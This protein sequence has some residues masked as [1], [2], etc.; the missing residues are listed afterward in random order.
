M[1]AKIIVKTA[2]IYLFT[3][4]MV[5]FL[6][7]H[8]L[9]VNFSNAKPDFLQNFSNWDAGH[10]LSIAE[11]GYTTRGEYA[12]FP[13][14]PLAV[15]ILFLIKIPAIFGGMILSWLFAVLSLVFFVRLASI[16]FSSSVTKKALTFLLIFPSVFY[17]FLPYSES[18]FLFLV[19]LSFYFYRKEKFLLA[20]LFAS[21]TAVTRL[22]GLAVIL[23]LLLDLV[24]KNRKALKNWEGRSLFLAPLGFLVF[25]L[26]L[27]IKT[28]D[29]LYFL[30]AERDWQRILSIP[31]L[32]ILDTWIKIFTPGALM[33]NPNLIINLLFTV[34]GLGLAVRSLRRLSFSYGIYSLLSVA[35]PVLSTSLTSMTRFLLPVFPVFLNLAQIEEKHNSKLAKATLFTFKVF[36]V[37]LLTVYIVSFFNGYGVG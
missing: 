7:F 33:G 26:L 19:V 14:Y 21:L 2:A 35:M 12:F 23:A 6:G 15:S 30:I 20:S 31:G 16:D 18:L 11:N 5:A 13:L 17:L 25:C 9:P 4:L 27:K 1:K 37:L 10:F 28:G 24:I 29:P 32:S 34:L 36:C 3:M 8:L 22:A